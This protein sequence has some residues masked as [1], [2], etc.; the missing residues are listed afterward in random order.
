MGVLFIPLP[1]NDALLAD[2]RRA[3][4]FA[5]Y[6]IELSPNDTQGRWPTA[7]ELRQAL[8][9]LAGYET[10]Y[11]VGEENFSAMVLTLV[12]GEPQRGQILEGPL[13]TIQVLHFDGDE[14]KPLEFYLPKGWPDLHLL[15]L[16]H[17]A[18]LCGPY[19]IYADDVDAP[20]M[21]G[22]DTDLDIAMARWTADR[23]ALFEEYGWGDTEERP[24]DA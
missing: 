16:K 20:V 24:S 15:I 1:L 11:Y 6:G 5:R 7:V 21:I 12:N 23:V 2:P 4:R 19:I 10:T 3:E 17:V 8:D 14:T 9:A 22:A 13:A 18:A